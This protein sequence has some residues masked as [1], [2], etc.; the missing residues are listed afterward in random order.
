[1]KKWFILFLTILGAVTLGFLFMILTG[2][3]KVSTP[4]LPGQGTVIKPIDVFKS[5]TRGGI[6]D[7]VSDWI[8]I[9]FIPFG[10]F[11]D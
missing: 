8:N 4:L 9:E 5:G 11:K 10:A 6:T 3:I 1:M 2:A 7:L